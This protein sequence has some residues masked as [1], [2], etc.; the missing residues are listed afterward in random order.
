MTKEDKLSHQ[1]IVTHF[2]YKDGVLTWK[3]PTNTSIL[4]GSIAGNVKKDGYW[5]ITFRG[6]KYLAHRVI[7][8]LCTGTWPEHQI[9][10]INGNKTDNRIEN[11][12]DVT[13]KQ[14]CSYRHPLFWSGVKQGGDLISAEGSR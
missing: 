10:H 5:Y 8:N 4:V 9:D 6:E 1:E 14:N 2:D 13:P 7:W 11:L 3:I 12:R